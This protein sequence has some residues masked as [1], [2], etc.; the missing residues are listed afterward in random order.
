MNQPTLPY[1]HTKDPMTSFKAAEKMVKS[2]KLSHQ[3]QQVFSA[4]MDVIRFARRYHFTAKELTQSFTAFESYDHA[5]HKIQ[6]RLSGLRN[7]GKIERTGEKRNG[8]CVW[9]LI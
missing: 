1:A 6:R 2:G 9:R 4:I 7:K 8:C 5:Y 3:E